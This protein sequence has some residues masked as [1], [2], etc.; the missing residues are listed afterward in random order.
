MPK[1]RLRDIDPEALLDPTPSSS[2]EDEHSEF[3][4]AE[5]DHAG[6]EHYIDVGK[7][8]LRKKEV[9]PLGPQYTGSKISRDAVGDDD[10]DDP[11]A[12]AFDE[13]DSDE[14]ALV[15]KDTNG[16]ESDGDSAR[17]EDD[18]ESEQ[19]G[20]ETSDE[21]EDMDGVDGTEDE[22]ED[23]E[24]GSEDA[25][26]DEDS[27]NE[28]SKLRRML[29][30]TKPSKDSKIREMIKDTKSLTITLAAAAQSDVAKGDAIKK[31]R[32]TFDSL[33][34]S[35]IRLQKAMISTNSMV[36][37]AH[38]DETAP[39]ASIEAAETAALALL[40]SLADLRATLDEARAG[41][42]RKRTP[43]TPTTTSSDIWESIRA[44]EF[45]NSKHRKVTLEKWSAKTRGATAAP[46]KGRL[47]A[48]VQQTLTDVLDSQL[49][50]STHLIARTQTPRSCAPLQSA[51]SKTTDANIYDDADFYGL[52]LKELL[53]QRSADL[54]ASGTA[55]FVVQA[56][57]QVAREA[58]TKKAVDTKASKG[59]RLRYT[60]HEKLQ[61]FMAPEDRGRWGERQ[62]DE[63]FGSLFGQR[64]GLG[65]HDEVESEQEDGAVD[66][67]EQGLTLF[68]S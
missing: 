61:N 8:K 49:T 67:A 28:A 25:S 52:L 31:Q 10:S 19:K 21:D 2:S 68:R 33:L 26:D 48:E 60:V 12:R 20:D 41:Q 54:S 5:E 38:Q 18:S 6:R 56:P 1:S 53:E 3:S 63:L 32:K 45:A 17:S 24:Q 36:A 11:F 9:V 39:E 59:R 40:N 62:R 57:W 66:A 64:V 4:A 50:N 15:N 51:S 43:Y 13:N 7:S 58:K 47:N 55:E 34:N 16:V 37:N 14:D 44:V 22:E 65:E 35:R 46:N 42:K 30:E 29:R 27:D 23:D